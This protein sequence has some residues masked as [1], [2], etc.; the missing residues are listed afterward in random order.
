VE[1]GGPVGKFPHEIATLTPAE[2]E[3]GFFGSAAG[4]HKALRLTPGIDSTPNCWRYY[5]ATQERD[6]L[7]SIETLRIEPRMP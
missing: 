6:S 5:P 1:R 7:V 2:Y 4:L 3:R